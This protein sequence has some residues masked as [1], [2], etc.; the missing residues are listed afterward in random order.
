MESVC[1]MVVP[2]A[3][4]AFTVTTKLKFAVVLAAKLEIVQVSEANVQVQ[5]AGPLRD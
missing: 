1:V 4:P 5:V 2:D 3:V